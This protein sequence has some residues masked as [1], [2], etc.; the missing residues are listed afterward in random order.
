MSNTIFGEDKTMNEGKTNKIKLIKILEILR[1][2][3][4]EEHYMESSELI[5]KLGKMGV[6]VDRRTL[7]KDIELLNEFGYEIIV[8]KTTLVIWTKFDKIEGN[9]HRFEDSFRD[10]VAESKKHVELV[11][12]RFETK[13]FQSF[14]LLS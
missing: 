14:F 11:F 4:D 10:A 13:G 5:Q 9:A 3:T 6:K 7:A 2:E 12:H 8:E 1:Q